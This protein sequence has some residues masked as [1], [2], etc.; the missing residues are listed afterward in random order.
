MADI[1]WALTEVMKKVN[2][3]LATDKNGNVRVVV[4]ITTMISNNEFYF[5]RILFWGHLAFRILEV[6]PSD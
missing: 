5:S 3:N 1:E 2:E 4:D 6:A